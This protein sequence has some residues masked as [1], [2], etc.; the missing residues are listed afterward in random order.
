MKRSG[1]MDV[2]QLSGGIHRYL[3][4]YGIEGHFKGLNFT[5][6]K[7]VAVKPTPSSTTP[8]DS[9]A[10]STYEV[11][12]RCLECHRE[13]DELCG[14]RVCTVCRDLVLVCSDCRKD[15]R[16][17][18]CQRHFDLKSCYFTFLDVFDRD[19]LLAQK[20]ELLTIR[21]TKYAPT[22]DCKHKNIRRTLSRQ[23]KTLDHQ[24][25]WMDENNRTK[26]VPNAPRR[27][28]TC[29][30]PSTICDGRC[31]GF[32]KTDGS[33]QKIVNETPARITP[34]PM[35]PIAVGDRVQ[36]GIDWNPIRLGGKS[37]TSGSLRK[38]VVVEVK[39]WAGSDKDC[40]AVLWD[41][42]SGI[43]SRNTNKIQPQIYRWGVLAHDGCT[44]LYDVC[45]ER[46]S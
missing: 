29:M 2:H 12:G 3:E 43:K 16:E 5:F 25:R 7:R 39:S 15:M 1:I 44:R 22:V 42:M 24:I 28:R 18:H 35:L 34:E 27:C 46:S 20:L 6:D 38:G 37:D 32:W 45:K 9:A 8:A 10:S 11:V 26:G 30:E 36:P 14:S 21:D 41:D 33:K 13:F 40:V 4:K 17:F 19:Q 23:T 31:W